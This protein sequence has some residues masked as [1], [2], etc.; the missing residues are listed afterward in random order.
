MQASE[1]RRV[2]CCAHPRPIAPLAIAASCDRYIYALC[3]L[4][5]RVGRSSSLR[6]DLFTSLC[7]LPAR[8]PLHRSAMS[9]ART[10]GVLTSKTMPQTYC[11]VQLPKQRLRTPLLQLPDAWSPTW[12]ERAICTALR[13]AQGPSPAA[14]AAACLLHN[15]H[16]CCRLQTPRCSLLPEPSPAGRVHAASGDPGL[17]LPAGKRWARAGLRAIAVQARLP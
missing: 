13:C 3:L 5:E 12:R 7:R 10:C 1:R 6:G 8:S 14:A 17:L 16:H 11:T 2:A 4:C 15:H 9:F